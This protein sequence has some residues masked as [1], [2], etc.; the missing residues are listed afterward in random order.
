MEY[1]PLAAKGRVILISGANRGIGR[2]IAERLYRAGYTLSLGARKPESLKPV[3]TK[4]SASRVLA[5]AYDAMK[6]KSA[7]SLGRGN[8][9]AFRPHRWRR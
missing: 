1:A 3:M 8:G 4:M 2:A 5:H 6:T 7:A 9:K